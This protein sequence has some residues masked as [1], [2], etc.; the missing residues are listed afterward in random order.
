LIA[1]LY[2]LDTDMVI[3]MLRGLKAP[4]RQRTRRDKALALVARCREAQ[5]KGDVVGLS[6]VTVSELE[7]GAY[8]SGN[9][10]TEIIAV[11]KILTP[12][13][14][15]DY[16]GATCPSHYGRIRH[17]LE[18]AGQAI[19]AMDLLIAAHALAL[20]ATLV[21]NNLAHFQ[22]ISGLAVTRWP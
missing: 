18:Q 10:D 9:Y 5:A 17:E 22:R 8:N 20:A 14:V 21:T 6:A 19:G 1:V 2:I 3:F 11:R 4:A 13:E 12:F 16:D 7:F 15:F